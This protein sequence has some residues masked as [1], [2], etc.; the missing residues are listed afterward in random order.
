ME[1][2]ELKNKKVLLLSGNSMGTGGAT[3]FTI[4]LYNFLKKYSKDV[5]VLFNSSVNKKMIQLNPHNMNQNDAIYFDF[6]TEYEYNNEYDLCVIT[7]VPHKTNHKTLIKKNFIDL[8]KKITCK[9][10]FLEVGHNTTCYNC[11]MY[12]Q[13][14]KNSDEDNQYAREFFENIDFVIAHTNNG[15]FSKYLKKQKINIPLKE[16]LMVATNFDELRDSI[17]K[18]DKVDRL[19]Y[20]AGRPCVYKGLYVILDFHKNY[21][22]KNNYCTIFEGGDGGRRVFDTIY[23]NKETRET[24]SHIINNL[25]GSE[26]Y[27]FNNPG[28][29]LQFNG[30]YVRMEMLS[31]MSK[32]KFGCFFS[33]FGRAD[34]GGPFENVFNEMLCAGIIPIV[35]KEFYECAHINRFYIKN[36]KPE[37]MGLLI[38]D[39]SNENNVKKL[40]VLMDKLDQDKDLYNQYLEKGYSFFKKLLDMDVI[41]EELVKQF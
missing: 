37:D 19:V 3:R 1:L 39:E 33:Y 17:D 40:I 6:K 28:G 8:L 9:K 34:E 31:R 4:D 18:H 24:H 23:K 35:R 38:Y 15:M 13:A 14:E 11:T 5:K 7:T 20:F 22:M 32:A 16:A 12:H 29:P 36:I 26:P 10:I 2:N 27:N 30:P 21:L 25:N 41:L